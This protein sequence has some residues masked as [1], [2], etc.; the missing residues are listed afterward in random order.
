MIYSLFC[1]CLFGLIFKWTGNFRTSLFFSWFFS[2]TSVFE[3]SIYWV[4]GSHFLLC[5]LFFFSSLWILTLEKQGKLT[6]FLFFFLS[7]NVFTSV[8]FGILSLPFY[9]IFMRYFLTD[10]RRLKSYFWIAALNVALVV[11]F[12]LFRKG[13]WMHLN[14]TNYWCVFNFWNFLSSFGFT[15]KAY[16]QY[17]LPSLLFV[18][19]YFVS[20]ALPWVGLLWL[21]LA[22]FIIRTQQ[23]LEVSEKPLY[24]FLAL[25]SILSLY[26]PFAGR[27]HMGPVVMTWGRYYVFPA[28]CLV[29]LLS[30]VFKK[31]SSKR[32]VLIMGA[33]LFISLLRL[34]EIREPA[35]YPLYSDQICYFKEIRTRLATFLEQHPGQKFS[36][37]EKEIQTR[38]SSLLNNREWLGILTDPET[39]KQLEFGLSTSKELSDYARDSGCKDLLDL[40]GQA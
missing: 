16:A 32:Q 34:T 29:L 13:L 30:L 10:K 39:L 21:L 33:V 27:Y 26:V 11:S 37:R 3:E 17:F 28:A 8:V 20:L 19:D 9:L 4:C 23:S 15:L 6:G 5:G 36:V 40:I 14:G 31:I 7:L 24:G 35:H 22:D 25:F 18:D 1:L 38:F 2:A 12:Y